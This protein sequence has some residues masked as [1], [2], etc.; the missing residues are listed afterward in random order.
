MIKV[1]SEEAVKA[2]IDALDKLHETF[3][4]AKHSLILLMDGTGQYNLNTK[5]IPDTLQFLRVLI[6]D[7]EQS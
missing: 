4:D 5:N 3:D 7:L 2:S 6:D 1:Q